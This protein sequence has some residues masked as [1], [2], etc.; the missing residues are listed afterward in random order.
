MWTKWAFEQAEKANAELIIQLGDFGFGWESDWEEQR[1][2]TFVKWVSELA[3]EF[4][5]P[6]WWLDGN[7][8]NFDKLEM[9]GAYESEEPVKLAPG[10]T[11]LPRGAYFELDGVRYLV[12]GGA[13][14][15]DKAHRTPHTSWWPQERITYS[16]VEDVLTR[17]KPGDVDVLL[18]HDCPNSVVIPG[19]RAA[20]KDEYPESWANRIA[21]RAIEEALRP[22]MI[23]HGHYHVRHAQTSDLGTRI[24][25]LGCDGDPESL[26]IME[27]SGADVER[28]V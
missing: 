22:M 21:L 20:W 28:D 2:G 4:S 8:E 11:Y 17:F 13:Y 5:I 9:I 18:T 19:E 24:E 25:G 23:L 10:V 12:M 15:V 1:S 3:G 27:L 14:S 26:L 6:L 7:H 16:Q